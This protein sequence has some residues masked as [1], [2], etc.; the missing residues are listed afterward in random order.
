M[1]RLLRAI[2]LIP[3]NG[4]VLAITGAQLGEARIPDADLYK[5]VFFHHRTHDSKNGCV[6]LKFRKLDTGTN[7]QLLNRL[8]YTSHKT[9]SI[10]ALNN[11]QQVGS[12]AFK[13][14]FTNVYSC[15]RNNG[16]GNFQGNWTK[17]F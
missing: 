7:T 10:L 1:D 2:L 9:K 15:K 5:S 12:Y 13:P 8:L 14:F 6:S 4:L 11:C 3:R 17:T 16:S